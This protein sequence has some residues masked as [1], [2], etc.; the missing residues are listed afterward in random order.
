MI[1]LA[2]ET[3]YSPR[4]RRYLPEDFKFPS[5]IIPEYTKPCDGLA[6]NDWICQ[7]IFEGISPSAAVLADPQQ[8]SVS[9]QAVFTNTTVNQKVEIEFNSGVVFSAYMAGKQKLINKK[10]KCK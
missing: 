6:C 8:S 5:I 10:I 3:M 1:Y 4:V 2:N 9:K 7:N